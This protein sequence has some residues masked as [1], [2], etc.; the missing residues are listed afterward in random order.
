MNTTE[1]GFIVGFFLGFIF[2][3]PTIRFYKSLKEYIQS[4]KEIEFDT[5]EEQE[6]QELEFTLEPDYYQNRTSKD[7]V[8]LFDWEVDYIEEEQAYKMKDKQSRYT[9]LYDK[10]VFEDE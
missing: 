7:V 3:F 6:V 10:I 1:I 2:A 8:M 4:K 5:Q 9:Y